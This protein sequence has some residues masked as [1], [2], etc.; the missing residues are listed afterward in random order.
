MPGGFCR[1]QAEIVMVLAGQ[2]HPFEPGVRQRPDK[3]V[4]IEIGRMKQL[5]LFV[6]IAS[7]F[8]SKSINCKMDEGVHLHVMPFKLRRGRNRRQRR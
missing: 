4:R 8:S 5:L 3:V 6:S 2:H 7:L 1:P